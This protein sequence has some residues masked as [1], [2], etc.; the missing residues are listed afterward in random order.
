MDG[1]LLDSGKASVSPDGIGLRHIPCGVEGSQEGLVQGNYAL[2]HNGSTRGS[3]LS[4]LCLKDRFC[5]E[6]RGVGD[7]LFNSWHGLGC[8]G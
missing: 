3:H 6:V 7:T 5:F 8:S 2:D 4:Q 1:L